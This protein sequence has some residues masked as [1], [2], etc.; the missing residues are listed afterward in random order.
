M[1][2]LYAPGPCFIATFCAKQLLLGAQKSSERVAARVLSIGW[3]REDSETQ[4]GVAP[5]RR[6]AACVQYYHSPHEY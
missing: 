6:Y 4:K 3:M 5:S 2:R 1:N